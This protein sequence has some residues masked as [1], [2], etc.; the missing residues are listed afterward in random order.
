[1]V[2]NNENTEKIASLEKIKQKVVE[3]SPYNNRNQY[4]DMKKE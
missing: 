1:M 2:Q 3:S 4:F